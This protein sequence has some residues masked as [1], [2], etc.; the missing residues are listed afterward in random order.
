MLNLGA[1][2]T[3][4]LSGGW[5]EVSDSIGNEMLISVTTVV[6]DLLKALGAGAS[7]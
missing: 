3:G 1:H 4:I 5:N 2:Y 7:F 6:V